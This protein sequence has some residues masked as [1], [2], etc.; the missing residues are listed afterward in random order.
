M[1]PNVYG[2]RQHTEQDKYECKRNCCCFCMTLLWILFAISNLITFQGINQEHKS[3]K[4]CDLWLPY[5]IFE[6]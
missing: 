3:V 4:R 2:L 6:F 1:I 5:K